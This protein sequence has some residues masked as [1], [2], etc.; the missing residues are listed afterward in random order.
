[1]N[2]EEIK[3]AAQRI[4]SIVHPTPVLP[5]RFLGELGKKVW[6]KLE[7]LNIAGSF[8]IRGAFNAIMQMTPDQLKSGIIAA[9]AGNHAQGI[10]STCGQLGIASTIFMPEGT[11]LIK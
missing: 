8:K 5:A 3:S 11:P 1:M 2:P 7:S 10:A 6:L 4:K 9:S